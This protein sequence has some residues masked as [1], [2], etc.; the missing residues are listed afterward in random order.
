MATAKSYGW[1]EPYL[2]TG[3]RDDSLDFDKFR[4]F[5]RIGVGEQQRAAL[6]AAGRATG[7]ELVGLPGFA[8]G[9]VGPGGLMRAR[10]RILQQGARQIGSDFSN[11][12]AQQYAR[13]SDLLGGLLRSRQQNRYQIAAEERNKPGFWDTVAGIGGAV[14]GTYLPIPKYNK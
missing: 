4:R 3:N 12:G 13:E 5:G 14:A 6:N 1:A 2:D 11:I 9:G 8:A 10:Q 7:G